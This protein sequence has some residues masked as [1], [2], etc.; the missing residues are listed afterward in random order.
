MVSPPRYLATSK[1]GL[2]HG[3]PTVCRRVAPG[4]SSLPHRSASSTLGSVM[5]CPSVLGGR[6]GVMC[7]D[8]VL[9]LISA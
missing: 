9:A 1:K 5:A 7:Q 3:L 4:L 2:C 6:T 8:V